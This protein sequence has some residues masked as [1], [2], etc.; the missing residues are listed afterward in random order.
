MFHGKFVTIAKV[1]PIAKTQIIT[2]KVNVVDVN[3]TT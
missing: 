2:T 3:V 1:Q